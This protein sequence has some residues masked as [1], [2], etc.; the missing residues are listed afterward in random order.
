[1]TGG[2][3]TDRLWSRPFVI[4]VALNMLM[5]LVFY[6]LLTSL[7]GY[8]VTRFAA[9]DAVAGLASSSFIIG[10][11]AGRLVAGKFLDLVG[12]RRILFLAMVLLTLAGVAYIPVGDLTV[13]I[14][15]R[16]VH[17]VAFGV[18]NTALVASVQS[19]IP[20]TRLGEGNG[21]FS[22][23]TTFATALGPFLAL[24]L[25]THAG[26]TL[27]FATAALA[28]ALA[29]VAAIFYR[30]PE[31]TPTEV[32]RRAAFSWSPRS[33]VDMSGVKVGGVM[34]IAGIAY[35]PVMSFLAL[36]AAQIG[37]PG[38]SSTYFVTY[39]AA[40]LIARPLAG[41]IQDRYG[42]T[43]VAVPAFASFTIGMVLIAVAGSGAPIIVA[44]LFLGAGFSSLLS[45]M[46]TILVG[47]VPPQRV[48]VATSTFFL[49]LDGGSGFG[50]LVLGLTVGVIG[51]AGMYWICVIL[52]LMAA[53]YYV[54]VRRSG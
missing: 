12:R 44:G 36:Y 2:P 28:G 31:H 13:L 41:R 18:G 1:M 51:F 37:A 47:M 16:I 14:A 6:L 20:R 33:F 25:A 50:P 39:A 45:I 15:L 19:V 21:F 42:D 40:A 4:A 5:S 53:G 26:F 32:Q 8:A 23:A 38:A 34:L 3:E 35:V 11:V 7:A 22:V 29:V 46:L 54:M 43:V 17:G 9:S 52:T 30:V 49:L 10:A 27:V 48:A 24:W